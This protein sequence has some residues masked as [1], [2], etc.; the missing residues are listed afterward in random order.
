MIEGKTISK[1]NQE[2]LRNIGLVIGMFVGALV[3]LRLMG[4]IHFSAPD[5]DKITVAVET[6]ADSETM[7]LADE[8]TLRKNYGI[9]PRDVDGFI[10]YAPKSA[11]DA[12]EILILQAKSE[13]SLNSWRSIIESRRKTRADMYRNYR[14]EEALLLEKSELKIQG[15]Y[16]IFISAHNVNEVKA[17]VEQSFR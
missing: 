3:L 5:F 17:A 4:I 9:N 12:S 16:L 1:K 2:A 6:A 13:G 14:P 11:M 7:V 15:N 10:Y 8:A